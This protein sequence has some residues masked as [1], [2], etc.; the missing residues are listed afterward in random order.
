MMGIQRLKILIIVLALGFL[1]QTCAPWVYDHDRD[2]NHDQDQQFRE[3][4]REQ[5]MARLTVQN[6]GDSGAYGDVSR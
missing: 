5:A 1:T 6:S 4:W 3:H 2:Y